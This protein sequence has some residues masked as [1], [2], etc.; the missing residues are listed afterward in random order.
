MTVHHLAYGQKNRNTPEDEIERRIPIAAKT[1]EIE[2]C[3][4][5]NPPLPPQIQQPKTAGAN[6]KLDKTW[7]RGHDEPL[8]NLDAKLRGQ[9]RIEIK[10]LQRSLSTTSVYV[11]HDQM[12]G[13]DACRLAGRC[14]WRTDRAGRITD[15]TL[16][17]PA[18]TFVATFIGSP[19][20]NLLKH[21]HTREGWS[22]SPK[23]EQAE[24]LV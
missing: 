15:R 21:A 20:M 18:T 4:H 10:R 13:D 12:D 6:A 5:R 8:S 7:G 9:M 11:R 24:R 16:R 3:L 14:Q 22:I 17:N 1:L 2:R 23:V 19:S